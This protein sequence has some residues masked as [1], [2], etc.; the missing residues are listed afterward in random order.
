MLFAKIF[1][2]FVL[3]RPKKIHRFKLTEFPNP[4][5]SLSWRVSGTKLDGSRVR[6]NFDTKAEA[7]QTLAD[8]QTS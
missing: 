4:A 7:I 6:Q 8:L 2:N 3:A 1:A 5:G